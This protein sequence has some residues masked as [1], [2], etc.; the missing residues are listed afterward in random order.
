MDTVK[1]HTLAILVDNEAGVLSQVT[2]LFSR[3][4]YNIESI[5]VGPTEAENTSRMTIEIMATRPATE[6]LCNQ[7]RKLFPVH[8]VC[9]LSDEAIRRELAFIKVAAST[10]EARSEVVQIANI[11]RANIIDVSTRSMTLTVIGEESK[12]E[13]IHRLLQKCTVLEMVRAGIVALER[14]DNTINDETKEKGEFNYGKN[15]L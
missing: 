7:L 6:L 10:A 9:I 5:A 1:R 12:V 15:V 14:G 2:R 8:S 13:A 3:K 11:F 4:G